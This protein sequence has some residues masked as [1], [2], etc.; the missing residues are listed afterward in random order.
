MNNYKI[1]IPGG[2]TAS[3][4]RCR[5]PAEFVILRNALLNDFV[6]S[7]I[8]LLSYSYVT[9]TNNNYTLQNTM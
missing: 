3:A 6:I 1:K 5:T 4:L 9:I 7:Y 8:I 2:C